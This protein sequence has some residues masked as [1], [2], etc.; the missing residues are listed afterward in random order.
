V[1]P[2]LARVVDDGC[3]EQCQAEVGHALE[4]ALKLGLVAD[5][6]GEHRVSSLVGER[7]AGK[8]LTGAVAELALDGEPPFP[9]VDGR[10]IAR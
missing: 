3:V 2:R 6:T 7:H 8:C 10:S 1:P 4:V 5:P 9:S